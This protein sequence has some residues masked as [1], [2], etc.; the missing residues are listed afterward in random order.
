MVTLEEEKLLRILILV[1][2]LLVPFGLSA[3]VVFEDGTS[4]LPHLKELDETAK[5]QGQ[6][7]RSYARK[8]VMA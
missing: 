7:L 8:L 6:E 3:Q 1:T 4:D 5:R 2:A